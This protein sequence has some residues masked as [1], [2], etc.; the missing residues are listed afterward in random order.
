[1]ANA[2]LKNE[3][4]HVSGRYDI[5]WYEENA[6]VCIVWEPQA[7]TT[8]QQATIPWAVLRR[9]LARKDMVADG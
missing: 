8:T 3:P 7:A 2:N 9:A 5:W 6:G 4:H 1:M